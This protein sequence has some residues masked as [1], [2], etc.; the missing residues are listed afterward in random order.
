[1]WDLWGDRIWSMQQKCGGLEDVVKL[2]AQKRV[3]RRL[4]LISWYVVGYFREIG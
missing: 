3:G 1:M 4:R 2:S